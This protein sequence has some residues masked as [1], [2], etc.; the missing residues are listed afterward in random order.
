MNPHGTAALAVAG[1]SRWTHFASPESS[2][3]VNDF[4]KFHICDVRCCQIPSLPSAQFFAECKISPNTEFAECK[5]S[6]KAEFCCVSSFLSAHFSE[7][8][9]C[10]MPCFSECPVFPTAEGR[11]QLHNVSMHILKV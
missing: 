1:H 10:H 6:A 11:L 8:R 9:V 5:I 7:C 2:N 4:S 3:V